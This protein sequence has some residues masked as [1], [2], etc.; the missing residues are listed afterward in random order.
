[1][2]QTLLAAALTGLA[3]PLLAGCADPSHE[4]EAEDLRATL[5][6]LPGVERVVLDYTEPLTLDSGKLDLRV[7]MAAD[8]DPSAVTKVVTTTYDAFSDVHH[9]EEGDLEITLGDDVI[10]LRSF[11]PEAKVEAVEDVAEA[12]VA[13]LPSGAVEADINTQDVKQAPHVLTR[14]AVHV[15]KAGPDRLL[16]TLDDLERQF[17]DVTNA[18]W[19]VQSGGES[20][21]Q[22]SSSEGFPD[23][24]L[25]DR[26]DTIRDELPEGATLQLFDEDITSVQLPAGMSPEEVSTMVA[27]H[28]ALLGGAGKAYYTVVS[29]EDL[30]A[31]FLAGDCTFGTDAV[32]AR[33]EQ[34]FKADCASVSTPDTYS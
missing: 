7:Q 27:R 26:F 28:L 21:W 30:F 14:Y 17:G 16:Q 4:T 1:M 18:A 22:L 31:D 6:A 8:A 29:G 12:A 5:S 24:G 32:G 10:H 11:E 20:G 25:R 34:D 9:G 23:R 3:L 33:L 13:V 2:K 15:A 19:G